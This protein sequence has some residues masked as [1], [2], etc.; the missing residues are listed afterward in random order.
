MQ[1]LFTGLSHR[2]LIVLKSNVQDAAE[3]NMQNKRKRQLYLVLYHGHNANLKRY[4]ITQQKV[5]I[6]IEF[7]FDKGK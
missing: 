1:V 6:L 4:L 3:Y 2:D 5:V 7:L